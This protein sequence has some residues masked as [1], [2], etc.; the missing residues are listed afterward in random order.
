MS[1][2]FNTLKSV[3]KFALAKKHYDAA[4]QWKPEMGSLYDLKAR[5]LDGKPFDL[6]Q[7]KGKIT[8]ICNVASECGYVSPQRSSAQLSTAQRN[9]SRPREC[10]TRS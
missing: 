2:L 10:D 1:G 8:L 4:S 7:L 3:G 6:A 9:R 5:D